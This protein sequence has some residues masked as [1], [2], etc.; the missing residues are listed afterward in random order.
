MISSESIIK[1]I[2][3]EEQNV[4]TS[5]PDT[6]KNIIPSF[7]EYSP[8]I[9]KY[10]TV[11]AQIKSLTETNSEFAKFLAGIRSNPIFKGSDLGSLM[12]RPVQRIPRYELLL[13]ELLVSTPTFHHDYKSLKECVDMIQ[14]IA[15]ELNLNRSLWESH[16]V[17]NSIHM[18]FPMISDS[19]LKLKDGE[20]NHDLK[21]RRLVK[22]GKIK[23]KKDVLE[24]EWTVHTIH[25]FTDIILIKE[26]V[27]Q[28]SPSRS[29]KMAS[30]MASILLKEDINDIFIPHLKAKEYYIH[31]S[32][33]TLN[34][35]N[36]H[37]FEIKVPNQIY[38]F[39]EVDL[40]DA[41]VWY[42]KIRVCIEKEKE[43]LKSISSLSMEEQIT[44]K[45]KLRKER[46]KQTTNMNNEVQEIIKKYSKIFTLIDQ[47]E[48]HNDQEMD[49]LF[50]NDRNF[51]DYYFP[52]RMQPEV[53]LSQ[54]HMSK[55]IK[56]STEDLSSIK[57]DVSFFKQRK[58]LNENDLNMN[59]SR[60]RSHS[61]DVSLTEKEHE[62][63]NLHLEKPKY[64]RQK[65]KLTDL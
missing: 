15:E 60:D 55:N 47:E 49:K 42:E 7:I 12:I 8:Y 64:K 39:Q 65:A 41:L 9:N 22:K 26:E 28:G 27:K 29:P 23:L 35:H 56:L 46:E 14:S 54:L 5:F 57:R 11:N 40:G 58:S 48:E 2:D 45:L 21:H 52:K 59:I 53:D 1:K 19:T 38:L 18:G 37:T 16:I 44:N 36:D 10:S 25:L 61:F 34:K 17:L 63:E 33:A 3:V 31:T 24:K 32:I 43:N 20:I 62:V 13:K 30:P 4:V 51:L 50:R 6:F